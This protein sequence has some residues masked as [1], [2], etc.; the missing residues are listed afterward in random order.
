MLKQKLLEKQSGILTYS[1]TPPK[2]TNP[3]E[4]LLEISQ[5]QV[6][7]IRNLDIDAL[8]LYDIQDES[9][10]NNENRPF[11]FISTVDPVLYSREYLKEISV[12]KIIY[13]YVGKYDAEE[14]SSWIHSEPETDK[15]S[16]FVGAA[17]ST[18][19]V[20]LRLNDAYALA[21]GNDHFTLGGVT[22][23][24]R[25]IK[26][27]NE[28]TRILQKQEYGCSFFIS[29]VTYNIEASKNMLSDYYYACKEQGIKMAPI[30]FTLTPCGSLQTLEFMQ[31]LGISIP[32]WLENDL[33]HSE[34][35]LEKSVAL[36]KEVFKELWAY[37]CEKKIPI[38][39]NIESLSVRKLEI[40]ASI[41]LLKNIKELFAK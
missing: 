16:V 30:L 3:H 37:A 7:R 2:A 29:Q 4:K 38:G 24:E 36:S 40:E 34:D 11:P 12:P 41:E 10:R 31:W 13:R 5:R 32:K 28:H 23:P 27:Q 9:E 14:L 25:H 26:N 22:M 35:I 33:K 18:Q 19:E 15:Y 6:E 21:R 20:R 8:V 17:S 39:C 1:L